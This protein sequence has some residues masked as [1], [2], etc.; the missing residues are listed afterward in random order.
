MLGGSSGLNFMLW[1]RPSRQDYD[2]WEALGNA[3]WGWDAMFEYGKKSEG[4]FPPVLES[5]LEVLENPPFNAA[6]HGTSGPVRNSFGKWYPEPT[7]S[8]APALEALGIPQNPDSMGGSNLGGYISLQSIDPRN[9]TRSYSATAYLRPNLGRPNLAILTGA[10]ATKV[11]LDGGKRATGVEF[12]V[13]GTTYRVNAR[14]EVVLSAGAFQV[15]NP[16]CGLCC[17]YML[18]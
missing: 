5:Q 10:Q 15:F 7:T 18:L 4:F 2:D 8:F 9:A 1:N 12:V 11:V 3:G 16:Y 6:F 13:N 17:T 14:K